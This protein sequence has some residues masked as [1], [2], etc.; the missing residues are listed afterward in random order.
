MSVQCGRFGEF[1]EGVRALLI[2]KDGKPN[3]QFSDLNSVPQESIAPFFESLWD[4]E[5]HPLAA[6]GKE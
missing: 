6:L 4:T 5:A 1:K 3:W 2:D